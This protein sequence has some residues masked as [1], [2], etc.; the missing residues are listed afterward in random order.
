MMK[1]NLLRYKWT[2]LVGIA[3]LGL[4]LWSV[5]YSD[6]LGDLLSLVFF[7]VFA[8]S[9]IVSVLIL[10]TYRTKDDVYRVLIN[11]ILCLLVFPTISLG[12]SL[13]D[14]LFVMHLSR[15][16]EAADFLIQD[17]MAKT[18]GNVFSTIVSLPPRYSD[19]KVLGGVFVTSTKDSV[20]VR[21]ATRDSSALGH[22]GYLFRSDDNP[23][24]LRTEFPKMGY[25][26][27]VPHWFFFSQ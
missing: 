26:R 14:R 7:V 27:I 21:F 25:T 4:I 17:E 3:F 11:V 23:A 9:I 1:T 24:A 8:G 15:F 5:T 2:C 12:G 6:P 20:T 19:L 10:A 18:G 16:Q 13:R 22:Q